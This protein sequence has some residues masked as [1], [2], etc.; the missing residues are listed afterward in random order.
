ME[1]KALAHIMVQILSGPKQKEKPG[2]DLPHL[3]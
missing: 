2:N 3:S 1:K